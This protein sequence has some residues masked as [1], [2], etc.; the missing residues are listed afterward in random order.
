MLQVLKIKD[1]AVIESLELEVSPG[2]TV[3]TGET[4]AG[5]SILVDALTLVL[6]GRAS[7]GLVRTGADA[8]EV[9][10]LFD[11]S[12]MSGSAALLA[13]RGFTEPGQ[14]HP[15]EIAV[16]RTVSKS[17]KSKVRVNGK[18]E[19]QARL[20]EL[21]R[22][23]VDIYGQH[24]Y[25]TLLRPEKHLELLDSFGNLEGKLKTYREAYRQ[26]REL[27][28]ERDRLDMDEQAKRERQDLLRYR[29][30]EIES[31]GL[32][33]EEEDELLSERERLKHAETLKSAGG[34]SVEVLYE[35]DES[36]LGVLRAVTDRL[37][38]AA[39]H[40]EWLNGPLDQVSQSA[41]IL[42]DVSHELRSYAD[43]IESDPD[44]LAWIEDRLEHIKRLKR[45]YGGEVE[46]VLSTLEE[47]RQELSSLATQE[48]R[49]AE[50]EDEIEKTRSNAAALADELGRA[51]RK[52]ASKLEKSVE[53]ELRDLGM[54]NT[55]FQVRF[56]P[57]K[58]LSSVGADAV[59]FYISPNPG[60]DPKP[61]SRI[62][63]GGELSRIMLAL[64]VLLVGGEDIPTL[65]FDE[66]DEGVGGAVAEAVGRKLAALAG[67]H[68]VLCVTHLPQIAAS[69]ERHARVIK[70]QDKQRTW[71]EIEALD[72]DERVEELSRMMAGMEVT[73][74]ARAHA[75]EMLDKSAPADASFQKHTSKAG[76]KPGDA[77]RKRRSRQRSS[78]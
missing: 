49:A 10:A 6:G 31:A 52:V 5:K 11:L 53:A 14:D 27:T 45:K 9:E 74:T 25:Q 16:H 13:E 1:L 2:L 67:N 62:A 50:L 28:K 30:Q 75:R 70:H 20:F 42:E 54:N 19:T 32:S 66:I 35:A 63:S 36:V 59:S 71:T 17:G 38:E 57:L 8:A 4:G 33:P 21:G 44:R 15:P 69:A 3:L 23:L 43:G 61:L 34:Y 12:G 56:E 39:R 60:E 24:E 55:R 41:A 47:A 51:R 73:D 37:S 76:K 64:R 46:S 40:D 78:S 68:Q 26:L 72:E 58:K 29:I 65:V 48:E 7:S 77:P 18:V 22:C